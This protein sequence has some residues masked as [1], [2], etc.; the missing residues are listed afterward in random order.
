MNYIKAPFV[1]Y[2]AVELS[3]AADAGQ[4]FLRWNKTRADS[5][6]VSIFVGKNPRDLITADCVHVDW[7]TAMTYEQAVIFSCLIV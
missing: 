1:N 6:L 3:D 4:L 2:S 5:C 7:F